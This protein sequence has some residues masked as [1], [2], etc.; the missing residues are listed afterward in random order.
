MSERTDART[1]CL[2]LTRYH[3][4]CTQFGLPDAPFPICMSHAAEVL[5]FL[6]TATEQAAD[7]AIRAARE[8][9]VEE[10]WEPPTIPRPGRGHNVVY[11]VR[12]GQYIK[13]GHST[14]LALRLRF[15]P[16]DAKL[17]AIEPG[18]RILEGQRLAQFKHLL[19]ARDEWFAPSVDL[20]QHIKRLAT[21]Q[22]TA[23]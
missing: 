10:A 7:A 18:D 11:Y 19:R 8:I 6:N 15:Y 14:N 22:I 17:L 5:R 4:P 13:I 9:E 23:A 16:P 1:Q 12:I 20:L 3:K 2:A 21:L